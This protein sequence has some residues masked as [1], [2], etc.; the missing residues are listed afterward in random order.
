M[1]EMSVKCLLYAAD[2]VILAPPMCDLQMMR[3]H[4]CGVDLMGRKSI[5]HR[6]GRREDDR[7]VSKDGGGFKM[8]QG[9]RKRTTSKPRVKQ[10]PR[11]H[12]RA[13]TP[14]EGKTTSQCE[15]V[16]SRCIP[17]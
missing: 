5:C 15:K 10:R 4:Q 3:T 14:V 2:E 1:D 13:S 7:D 16:T 12:E 6:L 8:M 9:R 11:L 17:D